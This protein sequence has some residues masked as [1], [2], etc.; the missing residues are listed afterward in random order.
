VTLRKFAAPSTARGR[1]NFEICLW[2]PGD[3]Q[4]VW[5]V[6]C[7]Q[8][9]Q[10]PSRPRVV[11]DLGANI[12]AFSIYAAKLKQAEK[13]IALEPVPSTFAK[14][15]QNIDANGLNSVV[16]CVKQGIGGSNGLRTV[17]CGVSSP[18]SSMFYRGD[19]NFESGVTE[20][21]SIT[22]LQDL[23][24]RF[25]LT[26]VDVCKGDCEGGEVEALLSASDDVLRKIRCITMEYHFPSNLSDRKTIF[27]RLERA[28][29]Q[30]AS[31]ASIGQVATFSRP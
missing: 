20:Q 16:T 22:T 11:L 27:A 19:P 1:Q 26:S 21:V 10:V 3:V 4:T 15:Q 12:E 31:H 30:F 9:Y 5:A 29:F 25:E 28:G 2:E 17:Y 24:E 18:H 13:I 14:L 7:N 8:N 6:F 23:F